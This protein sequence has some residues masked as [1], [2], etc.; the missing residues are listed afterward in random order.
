[1]IVSL[2]LLNSGEYL[3]SQVEQ[4][5]IEPSCHLREPYEIKELEKLELKIS[6]FSFSLKKWPRYT[7]EE[8][9]LLYSRDIKT[10]CD[11][12]QNVLTK[13]LETIGKTLEELNPPQQLLTE[14]LDD[15]EE[16]DHYVDEN[17]EVMYIEE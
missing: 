5:G 13:Y 7:D 14:D 4:L 6:P 11:P 3:I 17:D 10:M 8:D 9:I 12:S 1:M 2:I 16:R 15:Y